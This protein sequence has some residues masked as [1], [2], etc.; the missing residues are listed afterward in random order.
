LPQDA[1]VAPAAPPAYKP[2]PVYTPSAPV[3][4]PPPVVYAP[5]PSYYYGAPAY[6]TPSIGLVIGGGWGHRHWH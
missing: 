6:F 4:A 5:A 1:G 2:P 3:Y